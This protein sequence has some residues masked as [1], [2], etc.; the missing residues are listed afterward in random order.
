[1]PPKRRGA[2]D[3][4]TLDSTVS[5]ST[6]SSSEDISPSPVSPTA[7]DIKQMAQHRDHQQHST[8]AVPSASEPRRPR[9]FKLVR[10][11]ALADFITLSNAACGILS[12]FSCL[13]F[14][15]NSRY[16]PDILDG[17][18]ARWRQTSSPYG[19]DLDSLADVVSFSVAPSVLAFTLG[20]RGLFDMGILSYFVC[21]GIGRLARFNVTAHA[22]SGGTGKVKF[23]QG[24]PVPTSVLMGVLYWRGLVLE[25]LWGGHWDVEIGGLRLGSFHPFS[26]LFFFVGSMMISEV[27]IPKP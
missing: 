3:T 10:S 15:I 5:S 11:L 19:K 8:A 21:C 16:E 6:T 4:N 9:R 1:M 7:D 25:Q 17:S 13:N 18:V 20:C 14:L 23:N 27:K 26:L 2:K 24:F 12:M 22:L